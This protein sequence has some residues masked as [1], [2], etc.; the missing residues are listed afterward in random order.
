MSIEHIV[1]KINNL[2]ESITNNDI[3]A[4]KLNSQNLSFNNDDDSYKVQKINLMNSIEK[5]QQDNSKISN[6]LN[7]LYDEIHKNEYI[8]KTQNCNHHWKYE[9]PAGPRDNGEYDMVC[10]NCGIYK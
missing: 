7:N 1:S 4:I 3:L 2:N 5:F 8:Y 10:K 6:L 9:F